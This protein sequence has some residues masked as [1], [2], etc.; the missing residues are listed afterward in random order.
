M[1]IPRQTPLLLTL[2]LA[3]LPGC[4]QDPTRMKDS[5]A[6]VPVPGQTFLMQGRSPQETP[7]FFAGAGQETPDAFRCMEVTKL[8]AGD[9]PL[10]FRHQTGPFSHHYG[11]VL[12]PKSRVRA[13]VD[14]PKVSVQFHALRMPGQPAPVDRPVMQGL[15]WADYGNHRDV[16]MHVICIVRER[17]R[18]AVNQ[19]YTLSIRRRE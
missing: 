12:P 8:E 19:G 3:G 11:F 5:P 6:M 15:G 18:D 16:P 9:K 1:P 4:A 13:Q 17:D 14:N 10:V 2:L 7:F